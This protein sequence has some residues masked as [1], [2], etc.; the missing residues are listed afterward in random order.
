LDLTSAQVQSWTDEE[1]RVQIERGGGG[2]PP[3][4]NTPSRH[5]KISSDNVAGLLDYIRALDR[6]SNARSPEAGTPD[7]L[8]MGAAIYFRSCVYCHGFNGR[9]LSRVALQ[10]D[11]KESALDLTKVDF[12]GMPAE[13]LA[14]L[15]TEGGAKMMPMSQAPSAEETNALLHFIHALSFSETPNPADESAAVEPPADVD[16]PP[17][18][19]VLPDPTSFAVVIGVEKHLNTGIPPAD[20]AARDARAMYAY[21]TQAMGFYPQ[22]VLLLTDELA[23][24]AGL[25]KALDNWLGAR[26][27][28]RSRVFV[29]YAGYGAPNPVT[30]EG[31]LVPYD[32]DPNFVDE[33]AFP[34]S[35]LY[36][37]LGMLRTTDAT[38]VLDACFSGRGE[39]SII[40]DGARPP[41]KTRDEKPS[42]NTVA[43]SASASNQFSAVV[44]QDR[45]GLLTYYLLSGLQGA[46]DADG[47]GRITTAELYSYVRTSVKNAAQLQNI[48][49]T[50]LLSA[51]P[52]RLASDRPWIVLVKPRLTKGPER[53]P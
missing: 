16:V 48:E 49:Q 29:Y 45:H 53:A 28:A 52:R 32:A 27:D 15:L 51:A 8:E 46:A 9:G 18:S 22:N 10:L 44:P 11:V 30:S 37:Y 20:F 4:G 14:S 41:V 2:M 39:R 1:L 35:R 47:D 26:V 50:P 42:A 3:Y 17:K 34:L 21:L 19:A 13:K 38:V 33:E 5:G 43:L 12:N 23:T 6:A 40:A 7:S 31:F 25:E 24:K 36:A